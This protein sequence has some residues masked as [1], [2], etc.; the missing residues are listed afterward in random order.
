MTKNFC[1]ALDC[2]E[3]CGQDC[4]DKLDAFATCRVEAAFALPEQE[5][6]QLDCDEGRMEDEP[7]SSAK[8]I[9]YGCLFVLVLAALV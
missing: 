5:D 3:E 8:S 1:D 6:C 4:I 9:E 7:T 2:V